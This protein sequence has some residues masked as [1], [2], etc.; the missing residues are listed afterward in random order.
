MNP[1]LARILTTRLR[2]IT[3]IFEKDHSISAR[4]CLP[5]ICT[6]GVGLSHAAI[7]FLYAPVFLAFGPRGIVSILRSGFTLSSPLL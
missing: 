2:E 5:E 1:I 6:I 7:S 4:G 3:Q